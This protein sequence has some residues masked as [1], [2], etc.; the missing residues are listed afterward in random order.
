MNYADKRIIM[1]QLC[2]F[3]ISRWHRISNNLITDNLMR[4]MAARIN[5]SS[6][7]IA[8]LYERYILKA[9]KIRIEHVK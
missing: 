8:V 1:L 5:N 4:I 6:K 7:I 3:K 2:I 9:Q